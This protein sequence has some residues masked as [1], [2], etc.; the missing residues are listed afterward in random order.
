LNE[1]LEITMAQQSIDAPT[2][3]AQPVDPAMA[4]VLEMLGDLTVDADSLPDIRLLLGG[5]APEVTRDGLAVR[6]LE[7]DADR[8]IVLRV[9]SST[10]AGTGRPCVYSIHGGGYVLGNR[11]MDDL[12]LAGWVTELGCVAV[13]V[14]YRLAPEHPYPAALDDCYDGLRWVHGHADELGIDP[15]RTGIS[16]L[17]AGGGLAAALALRA[18]DRGDLPIAFQILDSPMLDDRQVTPSSRADWLEVWNRASNRFGWQSYL[19]DLYGTD[20]I[21]ADAA[22]A[23]ATDLTGLPPAVVLVGSADGFRDEDV[24]YATRLNQ[25]GV[26]T[27]LHVYPGAPHG[28]SIFGDSGVA[29]QATIDLNRWLGA[30]LAT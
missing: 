5:L 8:G 16:G 6:E 11:M 3:V 26:P 13:S 10:D 18:R 2:S 20:A 1:P 4:G 27:E 22:P 17:S 12:R 24:D 19:G 30:Q 25:A 23:R 7:I 15:A 9:L 14:E 28:F 29:R 21:P